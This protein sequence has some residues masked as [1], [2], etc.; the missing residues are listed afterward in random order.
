M[1]AD[2]QVRL[3][4]SGLADGLK[5]QEGESVDRVLSVCRLAADGHVLVHG[6]SGAGE[7]VRLGADLVDGQRLDP[8]VREELDSI[9]LGD[10]SL[11]Q[12]GFQIRIYVLVEAAV[13]EGVSVGLDL[14]DQLDEPYRLDRL[15]E[16]LSGFVGNL[17][18]DPGNFEKLCLTDLVRGLCLLPGEIREAR[19]KAPYRVDDDQDCLV[20]LVLVDGF[21]LCQIQI[22]LQ[23][24][25]AVFVALE[26]QTEHALVVHSQVRIAR[27]QF[28]F[29]AEEAGVHV[30]LHFFRHQ[31][32][33]AGAEIV[34]LPEGGDVPQLL[35]GLFRNMEDIAVA[36]LEKIKFVHDELHRV[37]REDRRTAVH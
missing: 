23:L 29:H 17:V 16:G 28:A 32:L 25:R 33:A 36:L 21:R 15:V 10:A 35:F 24:S 9:V 27:I 31:R 11:V 30:D 5:D 19:R 6:A 13:A 34:V 12:V 18:T 26:S 37:L 22:R 1:V 20:E 2:R 4:K 3:G 8:E 7:G 14:K